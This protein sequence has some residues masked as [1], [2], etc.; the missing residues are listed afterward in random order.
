MYGCMEGLPRTNSLDLATLFESQVGA[1]FGFTLARCGSRDIA[2]DLTAE[3][4]AAA[5]RHFDA[6][7]GA[8]VTPGWLFTV[9]RRRLIDHW[10]A[11]ESHGNKLRRLADVQ[12]VS[13]PPDTDPDGRVDVALASLPERQRAAL[14]L[15]Y[16]D[17]FSTSE[18][19]AALEVS[20]K[21]AE[22]LLAR[23][24]RSFERA[25]EEGA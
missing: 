11:G 10:R 16:L 1:V 24:R 12:R 8:E 23:A 4:F 2:E 14:S 3:T 21:A 17:D 6:G 5:S 18:V 22:S 25:Y 7:R 9:A 20:Y 13:E 15:R 19:A